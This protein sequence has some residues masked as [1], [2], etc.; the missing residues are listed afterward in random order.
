MTKAF[1]YLRVSGKGQA[2]GDGFPRQ[3][4]AIRAYAKANGFVIAREFAD[5][6]VSG[7]IEATDRP[8]FAEMVAVLHSNGVRTVIVEKLDRLARD[9]M[10]QEAA[11]S[12]F[13]QH[14]FSL[15]SVA[16]PDLMA[17]DPSRTAFRKMMGVFAQYDKS[18]IVLKLAGA[19][20]RKRAQTGRCEGRKPFGHFEGETA[21]VGRMKAL[22]AEGL[23]FDKIAAKLNEEGLPTRTGK[24][25]HGVVINRILMGMR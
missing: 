14:G 15:V 20:M 12:Y 23:G 24:P 25:W 11:L 19:R 1:S 8:A 3:R 21:V 13:Q 5:E 22:R 7:A 10:V 4:A 16:E 2:S 18:M 6:G 9:L 17:S